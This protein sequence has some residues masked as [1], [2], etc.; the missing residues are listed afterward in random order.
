MYAFSAKPQVE[1]ALF[2]Y[3]HTIIQFLNFF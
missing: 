1:N 2:F 3:F